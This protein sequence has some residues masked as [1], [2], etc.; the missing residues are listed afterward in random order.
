M[1]PEVLQAQIQHSGFFPYK[2]V[3]IQTRRKIIKGG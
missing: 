3:K 1:H 2:N